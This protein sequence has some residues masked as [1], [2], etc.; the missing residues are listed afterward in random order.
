[1]T[2]FRRTVCVVNSHFAAHQ[3]KV[4]SRNADFEYIY[5]QMSLGN[6]PGSVCFLIYS[7]PV[8]CSKHQ[9][10]AKIMSPCLTAIVTCMVGMYVY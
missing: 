4:A 7:S 5:N 10:V 9:T 2:V 8:F 1:M 6:K 3:E